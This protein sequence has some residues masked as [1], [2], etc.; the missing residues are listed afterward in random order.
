MWIG[1][2]R[3]WNAAQRT[4][5]MVTDDRFDDAPLDAMVLPPP[6]LLLL[7]LL[8]L[9]LGVSST[10]LTCSTSIVFE[11]YCTVDDGVSVTRATPSSTTS[12]S[13]PPPLLPVSHEASCEAETQADVRLLGGDDGCELTML[14]WSAARSSSCDL[15][16]RVE[17]SLALMVVVLL[18]LPFLRHTIALGAVPRDEGGSAA[19]LGDGETAATAAA[20]GDGPVAADADGSNEN[21]GDDDG[22]VAGEAA[23][24]DA[25]GFDANEAAAAAA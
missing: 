13:P 15:L 12:S 6:L 21:A 9:V 1:R 24:E 18:L 19:T 17:R 22:E 4:D 7:L 5:T 2:R 8:L 3:G 23:L 20:P 14:H 11:P 10:Q 25:A 16:R